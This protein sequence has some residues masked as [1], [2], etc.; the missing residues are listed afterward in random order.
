M[1]DVYQELGAEP[2][3]FFANP[4]TSEFYIQTYGDGKTYEL[5]WDSTELRLI[6]VLIREDETL[7]DTQI[8]FKG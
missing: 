4:R 8:G 1:I 6:A 7:Q 3:H 2:V 5:E